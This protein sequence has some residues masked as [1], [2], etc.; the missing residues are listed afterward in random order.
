MVNTKRA[1]FAATL[2][3]TVGFAGSALAQGKKSSAPGQNPDANPGQTFK[4]QRGDDPDNAVPPG[5]EYK[6]DPGAS[7]PGEGVE[8][9]GRSK[10]EVVPGD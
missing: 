9:F 7:P 8:N 5:Q 10:K 3:V 6:E 2:A 1:L 4:T